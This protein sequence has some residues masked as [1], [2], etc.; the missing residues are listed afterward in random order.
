MRPGGRSI[1]TM[2]VARYS[3]VLV[4]VFTN[5]YRQPQQRERQQHP[6]VL[7]Q[8]A[9]Q[10]LDVQR[11]IGRTSAAVSRSTPVCSMAA[12]RSDKAVVRCG[13]WVG[14]KESGVALMEELHSGQSVQAGL[15]GHPAATCRLT[16]R[17]RL[18]SRG[19]TSGS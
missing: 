5:G 11:V 16:A 3:G 6:L 2:A 15:A 4:S 19:V 14:R 12:S 1:C 18:R 10:R 13:G 7:V 9:Q 8:D 17:G